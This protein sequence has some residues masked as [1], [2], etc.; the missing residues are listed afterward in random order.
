MYNLLFK[1]VG[2]VVVIS[3]HRYAQAWMS[4]YVKNYYE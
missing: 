2:T 3:Y 4:E 1:K